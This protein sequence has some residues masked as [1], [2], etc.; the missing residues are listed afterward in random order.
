MPLLRNVSGRMDFVYSDST[1]VLIDFSSLE[2]IGSTIYLYDND[3]PG[4]FSLPSLLSVGGDVSMQNGYG[5]GGV[6]M[7]RL[8]TIGGNLRIYWNTRLRHF[9]IRALETIGGYLHF[10]GVGIYVSPNRYCLVTVSN[11]SPVLSPP[12]V[13]V[14]CQ[15][16]RV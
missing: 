9:N 2:H 14:S 12:P 8:R 7:P 16:R 10:Y 3:F 5:P 6:R 11:K 15:L 13:L 4:N 1:D